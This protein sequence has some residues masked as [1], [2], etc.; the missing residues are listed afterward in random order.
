MF[1]SFIYKSEILEMTYMSKRGLAEAMV[2]ACLPWNFNAV[3][4]N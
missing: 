2:H 4:K 1:I 3:I